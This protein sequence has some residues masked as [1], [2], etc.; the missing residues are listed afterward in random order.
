MT[1]WRGFATTKKFE[2]DLFDSIILVYLLDWFSR[3]PL[4]NLRLSLRLALE[5][6]DQGFQDPSEVFWRVQEREEH[7]WCRDIMFWWIAKALGAGPHPLIQVWKEERWEGRLPRAILSTTFD[8][9]DVLVGSKHRLDLQPLERWIGGV[10]LKG[11][12]GWKWDEANQRMIEWPT[13]P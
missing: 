6:I 2:R 3:R 11:H 1:R 9:A 10:H 5:A 12:R 4:G 7:P 13:S 8:G